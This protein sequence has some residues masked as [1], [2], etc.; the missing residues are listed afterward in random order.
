[1]E[2]RVRRY[3]NWHFC[4]LL[5]GLVVLSGCNPGPELAPLNGKVLLD[6]EPLKF[7]S[8]MLQPESGQPAL[9]RIQPDGTFEMSTHNV[10]DGATVG[11][12]RIRISCYE[13][14]NPNFGEDAIEQKG[15]GKLLIRPFYAH[16]S[17]S[18]LAVE[19]ASGKNELLVIRLTSEEATSDDG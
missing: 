15:L 10:S 17:S 9:G 11:M 4:I 16:Y 2:V 19:V 7:G 1:M 13:G 6:G 8:V 18:G 3:H 5:L 14:Q 12:N